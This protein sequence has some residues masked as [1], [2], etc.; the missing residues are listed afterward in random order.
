MHRLL[1]HWALNA[2][3][4][5]ALGVL[6]VF[7]DIPILRFNRAENTISCDDYTI[8]TRH[9]AFIFFPVL[10]PISIRMSGFADRH[11]VFLQ[12]ILQNQGINGARRNHVH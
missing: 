9:A 1:D 7:A 10:P 4:L 8:I 12:N 2:M 3:G 6:G 5:D 11:L